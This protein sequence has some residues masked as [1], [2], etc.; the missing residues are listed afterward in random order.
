M[1]EDD[2]PVIALLICSLLMV[3][4]Y[5]EQKDDP[6]QRTYRRGGRG[7]FLLFQQSDYQIGKNMVDPESWTR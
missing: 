5:D 3:F 2:N 6:A 7:N 1:V 4:I